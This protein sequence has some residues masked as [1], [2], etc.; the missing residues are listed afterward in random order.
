MFKILYPVLTTLI[1]IFCF[2][3]FNK[4]SPGIININGFVSLFILIIAYLL[5]WI[6]WIIIFKL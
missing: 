2:R 3:H 6:I 4:P 5:S 1:V